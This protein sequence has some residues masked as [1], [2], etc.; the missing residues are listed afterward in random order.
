MEK[1]HTILWLSRHEMNSDQRSHWQKLY[2]D[3][4]EIIHINVT[5][6]DTEDTLADI[7]ANKATWERLI[8]E[9]HATI[10]AGVFP[11]AARE[12]IYHDLPMYEAISLQNPVERQD[13]TKTIVFKHVRW[14]IDMNPRHRQDLV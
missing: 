8:Q 12:S 9:N 4:V 7:R 10:V 13:G 3:D 6:Q 2:G 1:K 5:W 14:S 11:T